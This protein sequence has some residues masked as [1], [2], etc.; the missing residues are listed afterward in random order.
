MCG[1]FT[2]CLQVAGALGVAAFGTAYLGLVSGSGTAP[3]THAFA[4][5][6]AGFA[7]TAL[8]AGGASYR[9]THAAI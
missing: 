8:A 6:T 1:V 9:A 2:T 7:L 3:A 4:V 5:V